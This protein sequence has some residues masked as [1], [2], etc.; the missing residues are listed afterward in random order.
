MRWLDEYEKPGGKKVKKKKATKKRQ[1]YDGDQTRTKGKTNRQK[2]I[3]NRGKE[4]VDAVPKATKTA[5][6]TDK[7]R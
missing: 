7:W 2:K 5:H 1:R 3:K 6:F 4:K